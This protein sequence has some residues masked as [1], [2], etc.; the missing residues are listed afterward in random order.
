MKKIL[1]L[2][3]KSEGCENKK[4]VNKRNNLKARYNIS[5]EVYDNMLTNQG[6]TCK[7]CG[8][9]S[10]KTGKAFAVDHCHTTNKIRG[11]LCSNC[12]TALGLMSDD[13]ARMKKAIKYLKP[14]WHAKIRKH[15]ATFSNR[16]R[17]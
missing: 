15:Y 11:L 5:V 12:N 17:D 2:N 14:T 1:K 6:N 3:N 9:D 13:V 7:I 10:C 4:E 16:F 8:I